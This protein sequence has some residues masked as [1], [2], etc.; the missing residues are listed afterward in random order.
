MSEAQVLFGILRHSARSDI[1]DAIERLVVEAPDRKL[2]RVNVLAFAADQGF[3][4]EQAIN[5]FLHSSR[6][7]LFEMSWN[8]LCPGCGGVLDANTSLKTVQS[9]TYNCT[10]CAAG[11]EPTLDEMVEV[12]FTVSPR[13]RHIE[14]HNPHELPPL[15]YFRQIY[16]GSGIDL[17]DEGYEEKVDQFILES[18]EL[19]PGEKAVISLQ[20]PAEFTIIF[21]PVTHAAQFLDVKG[22]PSKERQTLSLVFDRMHRHSEA[23]EL[24]PGPLRIMMENHTDLRVLPSI[25]LANEALHTLLG[26]RRPF[27]TAKRLLS[28][29]TFR[30]IYR[31]DTID[32]DQR[33][34]IT[35]L[36]FLFTDL[37]GS[38]ELYERVGDLAAFDLVKT[39]FGILHEIVA[40][41]AGAVVKTIG[42]AVM[43]TFP[44]PDRALMAAMRMREAMLSLNKE[45]GSDDLLLKIGIHEG[46]CIAVSLNERQDYFGQT[47]NIASRVQHLATSREIFAT[48]SVLDNPLAAELMTTRGLTPQSHHVA[49]RGITDAMDI[50]AIP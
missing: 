44:T 13:V 11:Y 34:K 22:E 19:P 29:Q 27:L 12:T 46:P 1:V 49:L 42:D 15:E 23:I 28:N 37:R 2:N 26:Q 3:D 25:C 7:G 39:H 30:D 50:F 38:T 20:L 14:A 47:V 33:L 8:V 10:L 17:P 24:R 48:S 40:A 21:E 31:T 36:T 6:L 9:E 43:A 18:L 5:A 4:E 45:R 41:E 16:W 35:S 32:I